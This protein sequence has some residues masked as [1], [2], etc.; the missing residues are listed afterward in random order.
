MSFSALEKRVLSL[1]SE[2]A[3]L[4]KKLEQAPPKEP[5]WKKVSGAFKGDP[6]FLEAMALGRKW[7]ESAKPKQRKKTKRKHADS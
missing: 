3:E 5:W 1:E 2:L 7:R 6:A 4:K